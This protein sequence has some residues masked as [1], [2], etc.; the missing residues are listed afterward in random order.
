VIPDGASV[1]GVEGTAVFRLEALDAEGR[2]I[3]SPEVSWSSLNP[4]VATVDHQG[5]A[6]ALMSGQ[7]T[8]TAEVDGV[9][10]SGVLTVS[11]PDA[12]PV[13]SWT[14]SWRGAVL[15]GV[16]GTSPDD[17]FAVGEE[18]VIL[19]YDG[20]G[21]KE[22]EGGTH[23]FL[24]NVWGSA[25]DDVFI[26]GHDGTI[27]H[28]DGTTWVSVA[29]GTSNGLKAVWGASPEEVFAVG[30]NGTVLRFDGTTWG[31][32]ASGTSLILHGAWGTSR[33]DIFA[34]GL[35][36]TILHNDGEEWRPMASGTSAH[37]Q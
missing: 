20:G 12:E 25:P 26:V 30:Y 27:L 10:G 22:M 32:M 19:H 31:P 36:G 5:V 34:V 21:W 37:L 24:F 29:A 15:E 16:W 6:R 23:E 11:V 9:V 14:V 2:K 17:V 8:I 28:Y 4:K 33:R 18:G 1:S 13:T 35:S 3:P 7:A